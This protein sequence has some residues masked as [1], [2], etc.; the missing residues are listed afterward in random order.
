MYN[1]AV[2][3]YVNLCTYIHPHWKP[4]HPL[5]SRCGYA[6]QR[7]VFWKCMYTSHKVSK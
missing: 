7:M 1:R 2:Y 5:C 6:S 3:T 4:L